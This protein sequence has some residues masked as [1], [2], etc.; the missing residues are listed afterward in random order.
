MVKKK[1][2]ILAASPEDK[3]RLRADKE[4]NKIKDV[5]ELSENR[6]KF[7]IKF[8]P[9]VKR[10]ELIH[11]LD[12]EKPDIVHFSGHGKETGLVF[13]GDEG[14]SEV[15]LANALAHLFEQF[16]NDI[17]CVVL[18]ACYSESEAQKI[19]EH[20]R[21][22]IGIKNQI[23]DTAAIQFAVSFYDA[24]FLGHNYQVAC[25]RSRVQLEIVQEIPPDNLIVFLEKSQTNLTVTRLPENPP[26]PRHYSN[27]INALKSGRLVPFIGPGFNLIDGKLT[28]HRLSEIE[29]AAHLAENLEITS[30]YESLVGS[31]CP[32]C[33][34]SAEDLP[35][36]CPVKKA[37]VK[38]TT[39]A[40]PIA[41]EQA[42]ALAKM[43]LQC[44]AQYSQ[45]IHG[46]ENLYKSLYELL[47]GKY[48]PTQFY[49]FWAELPQKMQE[50]QYPLP[51]QLLVT[52]NYDDMLERAFRAANQPFDLVFYVAEGEEARGR[53]KYKPYEKQA[54]PIDHPNKWEVINKAKNHPVILK[55]YGALIEEEGSFVITEDHHINYL[56]YRE[57][58]QLLP[59]DI[60]EILWESH[61]ILFMGFNPSDPDLHV[62]INRIWGE[63]VVGQQSW[64]IHESKSGELDK[65]FWSRR[66]VDLIE[67]RLDDYFTELVNGI[68]NLRPKKS[69]YEIWG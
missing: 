27:I 68:E 11:I 67:S 41:N 9:A 64:M 45:L 3:Q 62:I 55:L 51:Y 50:K 34:V 18:N 43:N 39:T 54:I 6:E 65:A 17:E 19:H 60:L 7:E 15:V 40:C 2:L 49:S 46:I 44:L 66:V 8:R 42:L 25:Q 36:D 38:G 61:N 59:K 35:A 20:I 21:Y 23:S 13:E 32:V 28:N 47:R 56:A 12:I 10:H 69:M 53:F 24:I 14:K 58:G 48:S 33:L 4:F 26:T 29:L 30:P 63:R 1:I 5:L 52:T 37:L 16:S 31:P 22:V 57:I